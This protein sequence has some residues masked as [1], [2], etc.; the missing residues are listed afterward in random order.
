MKPQ[1][2]VND[3]FWGRLFS[4]C[5]RHFIGQVKNVH[6]TTRGDTHNFMF[7]FHLR[8]LPVSASYPV[9]LKNNNNYKQ[10]ISITW[11]KDEYRVHS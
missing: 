11:R 2:E 3:V 8:H 7:S 1:P 6:I 10:I 9:T 4:P 5:W